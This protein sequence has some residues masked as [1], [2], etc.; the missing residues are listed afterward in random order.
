MMS[1]PVS[2]GTGVCEIIG[3]KCPDLSSLLEAPR[4]S[5][6]LL[7][8]SVNHDQRS[9]PICKIAEI[10]T[11]YLYHHSLLCIYHDWHSIQKRKPFAQ[12]A[13]DCCGL[14]GWS[15]E[16]H[17]SELYWRDFLN[18]CGLWGKPDFTQGPRRTVSS[19]GASVDFFLTACSLQQKKRCS[20]TEAAMAYKIECNRQATALEDKLRWGRGG[21]PWI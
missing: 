11:S 13:E 5:L 18:F 2:I 16:V 17:S 19:T 3:R 14:F 21:I 4:Y 7:Q 8:T 12:I 1:R 9:R 6:I 20:V 10:I 15:S